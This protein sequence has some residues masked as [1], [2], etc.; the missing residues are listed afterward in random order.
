MSVILIFALHVSSTHPFISITRVSLSTSQSFITALFLWPTPALDF[1]H[2]LFITNSIYTFFYTN[3]HKPSQPIVF[4]LYN[5]VRILSYP[6]TPTPHS[7]EHCNF[8]Y[9]CFV[10]SPL[11]LIQRPAFKFHISSH[12]YN[13]SFAKN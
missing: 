6:L 3:V 1:L 7:S 2:Y 8:C 11:C 9:F 10:F 12:S 4:R 13:Y 5:F